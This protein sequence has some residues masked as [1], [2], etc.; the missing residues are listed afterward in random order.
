MTEHELIAAVVGLVVLWTAAQAGAYV[1]RRL[2]KLEQ[3]D[4]ADLAIVVTAGP[5]LLELIVGFTFSMAVTRYNQRKDCE[6]AEAN[7]IRTEYLRASLLSADEGA[8]LRALLKSYVS[9]RVQFYLVEESS[10][11]QRIEMA[12][13]RI[14]TDLWSL[15]KPR[16]AAQP[17]PIVAIPLAGVSEIWNTERPTDGSDR[18]PSSELGGARSVVGE[19]LSA[20]ALQRNRGSI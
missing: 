4:L 20:L 10:E 17:T 13:A 7:A 6:A 14:L 2:L 19:V 16:A 11:L 8:R 1:R 5:T 12:T 9:R 3:D 18:C 15:L